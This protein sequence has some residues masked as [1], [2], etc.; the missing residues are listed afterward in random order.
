MLPGK[1]NFV[2]MQTTTY[3]QYRKYKNN[4]AYFRISSATEW[5][6][7]QVMGSKYIVHAFRVNIMPDRNFIYD[8]TFDYEQNWDKIEAEEYERIKALTA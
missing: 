3:P 2:E 4:K 1:T 7:I 6:E 8:M 5:E